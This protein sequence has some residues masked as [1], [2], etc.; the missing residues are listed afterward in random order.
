MEKILWTPVHPEKSQMAQLIRRVNEIYGFEIKSYDELFNWSVNHISEFWE[1]IWHYTEIKHSIPYSEVVDDD[2]KMPGAKWFDGAKLNY[3]ENLLRYRDDKIAIH[4]KGEG[5]TLRSLTYKDL[6]NEVEKLA[7]SL[8]ESGVQKGD[9]ICGFIPNMPE[10]IIAML[11]TTSI[12]AIW[13]STSPDFGI[14][15]VLD[16]FIQ[17]KP[18]IIFAANGYFYNGKTFDSLDKLKGI[19]SKLP[20]VEKVVIVG[21][22]DNNPDLSQFEN[23]ILYT[24]FISKTPC[25]MEFE[26][27]PFDHPLYIM[28]S[29]GTTGLPKSI[30]HSAGGLSLIHI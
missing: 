10:A 7:Q 3:A 28:Y 8:K 26:Q 5:Q 20:S 9:R 11:A 18:K 13:S 14:K 27:V 24:D 25:P 21:Y 6:F 12:G 30:V 1:Q 17:I 15:G 29:S 16:R 23:G 2:K 4:F 19:L 22:T